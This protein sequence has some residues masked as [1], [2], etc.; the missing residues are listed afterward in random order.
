M[1]RELPINAVDY[2]LDLVVYCHS[3]VEHR[4]QRQSTEHVASERRGVRSSTR[5][6]A[7]SYECLTLL[8]DSVGDFNYDMYVF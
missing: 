6:Y 7:Y 8:D 3:S 2:V 1:W 5:T 4:A